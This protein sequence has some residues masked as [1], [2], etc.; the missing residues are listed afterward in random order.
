[1]VEEVSAALEETLDDLRAEPDPRRAVIA[2]YARLER[3][4][5]ANGLPRSPAETQEEYLVRLLRSLDVSERA[6]QRLTDLFERARFS[7]HAVDVGMKEDAI[8][9]LEQLRDELR[10]ARA[11]GVG[12][13]RAEVASS[14]AVS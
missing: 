8:E 3:A 4:L 9:A 12:T 2:A 6:A 11:A 5:A 13:E 1:M 10:R 14:G 7:Q